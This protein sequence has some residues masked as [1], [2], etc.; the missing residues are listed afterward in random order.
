MLN[1]LLPSTPVIANS[2][3]FMRMAAKDAAS[4]GNDV[5]KAKEL[6]ADRSWHSSPSSSV[7]RF[8]DYG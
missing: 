4:S 6:G 3:A 1:K 8:G 2:G 5:L 7:D